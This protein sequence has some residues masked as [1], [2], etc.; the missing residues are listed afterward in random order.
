M[1]VFDTIAAIS[2]PYGK[3]GVAMIRISGSDALAI[4]DA[5]FKPM[6]GKKLSELPVG[7]ACYGEIISTSEN[8]KSIDD[9]MAVYFHAPH[10]FTGEDTV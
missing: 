4:G 1:H 3:G 8:G 10:S 9:G 2:T 6:S 5:I 7:K